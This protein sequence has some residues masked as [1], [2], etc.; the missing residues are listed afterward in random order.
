MQT[1]STTFQ[2][3]T[4]FCNQICG[5]S[6]ISTFSYN[7]RFRNWNIGFKISFFK[8]YVDDIIISIDSIYITDILNIV[9]NYNEH[10]KFT[11]EK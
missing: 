11:L 2:Y 7:E 3:N 1:K 6:E 5:V 10:L 4:N 9:N 8:R